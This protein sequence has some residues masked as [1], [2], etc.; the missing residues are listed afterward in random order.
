MKLKKA[1]C[2]CIIAEGITVGSPEQAVGYPPHL[3]LSF[4]Y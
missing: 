1:K 3:F 4:T 2:A